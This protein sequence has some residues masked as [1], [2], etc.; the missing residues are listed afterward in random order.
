MYFRVPVPRKMAA[1]YDLS[2]A[3]GDSHFEY[4]FILLYPRHLSWAQAK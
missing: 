1:S 4:L 2:R 3:A